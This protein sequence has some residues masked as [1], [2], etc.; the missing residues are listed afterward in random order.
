[1]IVSLNVSTCCRH[2]VTFD[3]SEGY[4]CPF[5]EPTWHSRHLQLSLYPLS[6]SSAAPCLCYRLFE[7]WPW[8]SNHCR[9]F[10]N[11]W[12]LT[13]VCKSSTMICT[14]SWGRKQWARLGADNQSRITFWNKVGNAFLCTQDLQPSAFVCKHS[15]MF[16]NNWWPTSAFV[17]KQSRLFANNYYPLLQ[18]AATLWI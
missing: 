10:A 18:S 9:L 11:N 5:Q 14:P 2:V 12:G 6:T 16:A 15:H 17:C 4:I 13:L 8:F 1:M 3:I 7:N